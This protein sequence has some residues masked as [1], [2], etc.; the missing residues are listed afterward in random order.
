MPLFF[1]GRISKGTHSW[2]KKKWWCIL[3]LPFGHMWKMRLFTPSVLAYIHYQ[4]STSRIVSLFHSKV[5]EVVWSSS[6]RLQCP[7]TDQIRISM[8]FMIQIKLTNDSSSFLLP[9]Y[10]F[11]TQN[12]FKEKSFS[13]IKLLS[14]LCL[15]FKVFWVLIA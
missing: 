3:G 5:T 6:A 14:C 10:F 15:G 11:Q 7:G 4:K 2:T 8:L 12:R 13:T 1:G 9:V